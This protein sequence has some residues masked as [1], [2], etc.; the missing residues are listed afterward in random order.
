MQAAP[1]TVVSLPYPAGMQATTSQQVSYPHQQVLLLPQQQQQQQ[2]LP[3]TQLHAPAGQMPAAAHDGYGAA[4]GAAASGLH[5][6]PLVN[7]F[8]LNTTSPSLSGHKRDS[9]GAPVHG[10]HGT[11]LSTL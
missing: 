3:P 9:S 10:G 2:Q 11:L 1:T 7:S 6:M 8:N 5:S 4:T